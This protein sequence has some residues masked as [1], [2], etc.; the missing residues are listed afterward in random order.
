MADKKRAPKI[1]NGNSKMDLRGLKATFLFEKV[2]LFHHFFKNVSKNVHDFFSNIFVGRIMKFPE[3]KPKI[4][5]FE[6][7]GALRA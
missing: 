1:E 5:I 4:N 3:G 7:S 6:K 2:H